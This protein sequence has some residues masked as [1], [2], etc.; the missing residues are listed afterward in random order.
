MVTRSGT[1][2][3]ESLPVGIA[4][5]DAER[6]KLAA[7]SLNIVVAFRFSVVRKHCARTRSD[8]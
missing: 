8:P 7:K 2:R 3:I 6:G 1:N 4:P 5:E